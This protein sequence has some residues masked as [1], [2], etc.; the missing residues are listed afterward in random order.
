MVI[1]ITIMGIAISIMV[2]VIEVTPT[3]ITTM[4]I[5]ITLIMRVWWWLVTNN[6]YR[7]FYGFFFFFYF[8]KTSIYIYKSW[9]NIGEC[10]MF[11]FNPSTK[12]YLQSFSNNDRFC[13]IR[14]NCSVSPSTF[15]LYFTW[16]CQHYLT[17]WRK[18]VSGCEQFARWLCW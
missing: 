7:Y 13:F 1:A 12:E 4:V 9:W 6:H 8:L 11:L 5:V 14:V 3:S 10:F 2:L 15:C 16:V 18:L 17:W